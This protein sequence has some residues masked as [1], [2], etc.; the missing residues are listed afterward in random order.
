MSLKISN[1][2]KITLVDRRSANSVNWSQLQNSDITLEGRDP[3]FV[4]LFDKLSSMTDHNC[5]I[6]WHY[7]P[8]VSFLNIAVHRANETELVKYHGLMQWDLYIENKDFDELDTYSLANALMKE[9]KSEMI[10]HIQRTQPI[11]VVDVTLN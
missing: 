9:I 1:V 2:F 11:K 4:A 5:Q 7:D 8:S 3:T 6:R 10:A